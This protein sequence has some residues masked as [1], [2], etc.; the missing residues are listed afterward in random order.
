MVQ[1]SSVCLDLLV[2]YRLVTDRWTDT[3]HSMHR[4]SMYPGNQMGLIMHSI[5]QAISCDIVTLCRLHDDNCP[6]VGCRW[7]RCDR[8]RCPVSVHQVRTSFYTY[9]RIEIFIYLINEDQIW[10]L[11]SVS[12]A[13]LDERIRNRA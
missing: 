10:L 12:P 6:I 8:A 3:G 13:M 9:C 4:A 5:I 2:F 7:K 1:T 11:A